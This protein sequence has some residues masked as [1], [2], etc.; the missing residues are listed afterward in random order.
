MLQGAQ[1]DSGENDPTKPGYIKSRPFYYGSEYGTQ[2]LF[3]PIM[4]SDL[5]GGFVQT[6]PNFKI[7]PNET[8]IVSCGNASVPIT[9]S[10]ERVP[11]TVG[12]NTYTATVNSIGDSWADFHAG[13]VTPVYGFI[14]LDGIVYL[15]DADKAMTTFGI[16]DPS[17]IPSLSV[18]CTFSGR[19]ADKKISPD[20][21]PDNFLGATSARRVYVSDIS[22]ISG[23]ELAANELALAV[24]VFK[25]Q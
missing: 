2:N 7:I 10:A 18:S 24:P 3:T 6:E 4:L 14:I 21:L 5:T 25:A 1:M 11:Y 23:I 19:E 13:T 9:S 12:D 17:V 8:Y 16:T 20:L 15:T 22:D